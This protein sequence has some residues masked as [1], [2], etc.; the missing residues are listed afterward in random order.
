MLCLIKFK[1]KKVKKKKKFL[2]LQGKAKWGSYSHCFKALML[3][4]F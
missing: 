2:I 4:I 3:K 1:I